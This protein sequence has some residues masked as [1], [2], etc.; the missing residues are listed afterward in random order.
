LL[1]SSLTQQCWLAAEEFSTAF[2][3]QRKHPS[4]WDASEVAAWF[5]S[6]AKGTFAD[7]GEPLYPIIQRVN[8]SHTQ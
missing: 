6:V 5:K 1:F 8:V 2:K 7:V 3:V 4:K